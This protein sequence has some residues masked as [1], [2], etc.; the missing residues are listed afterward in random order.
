MKMNTDWKATIRQMLVPIQY[1]ENPFSQIENVIK[2]Y[3]ESAE[4][5]TQA[6]QDLEV[7]LRN[8][9]GLSFLIQQPHSEEVVRDYLYDLLNSLKEVAPPP[10]PPKPQASSSTVSYKN[11]Q[12]MII[13]VDFDGTI[14]EHKFPDIG[15][16]LPGAIETLRAMQNAGH[17]LI[18]FTCREDE[19]DSSGRR[20]LT[21]AVEFC[22]SQG[23]N[24]VSANQT[25]TQ[26]DFR[27]MGGRKVYA[28]LYIDD[29]NLGGFPGWEKIREMLFG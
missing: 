6:V 1:E 13:A 2:S 27:P 7:A 24:F 22:R 16:P 17:R 11:K 28:D 14:V 18:L 12:K 21:E 23:I 19:M 4:K 29:R 15:P 10:P 25:L 3:T 5:L 8:N 26:D 9:E 20:Y